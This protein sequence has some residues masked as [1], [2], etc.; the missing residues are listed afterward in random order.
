MYVLAK[1]QLCILKAIEATVLQG[2]SNRRSICT[3]SIGKIN[4]WHLLKGCN[5]QMKYVQTPNLFH[6]V[7]HEL[8]NGLLGK[9]FFLLPF[10][11]TNKVKIHEKTSIVK[12][13]FHVT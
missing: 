12:H 10:I 4:Y 9:L 7:F 5:L 11:T 3:V 8:R 1:F 2:S 6:R 13:R